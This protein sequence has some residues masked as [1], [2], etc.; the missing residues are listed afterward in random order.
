MKYI[1]LFICGIT[2]SS[3][4]L[5]SQN[6]QW[7]VYNTSNSGLPIN[8][9]QVIEQD[10]SGNIWIGTR[11][12]LTKFDG[13]T[14]VSW[15]P[16]NSNIKDDMVTSIVFDGTT[17][18]IGYAFLGMA[19][20]DGITFTH[21]NL[22]AIL[23]IPSY[24]GLGQVRGMDFDNNHNL[25]I[26]TYNGLL[27][28]D[29]IN[30]TRY[31][32]GNGLIGPNNRVWSVKCDRSTSNIVWVGTFDAGL[33]KFDGTNFTQYFF[34]DPSFPFLGG[35]QQVNRIIF[36]QEGDI[37]VTGYG[38][39]EFDRT[40]MQQKTVYT[41][42]NGLGDPLVWGIAFDHTGK[43]WIG[44]D[45]LDGVF[46]LDNGTWITYNETNSGFPDDICY[47]VMNIHVDA[48]NNVW[49]AHSSKGIVVYNEAGNVGIDEGTRP[50]LELNMFPNP[51]ND[52]I[53]FHKKTSEITKLEVFDYTGKL[54]K[55]AFNYKNENEVEMDISALSSGIYI[56]KLISGS[57][58]QSGKFVKK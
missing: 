53:A 35:L 57:S 54:V 33:L 37:W 8:N 17:I 55:A 48:F 47:T 26:A 13:T 41:S 36:D 49:M 46:C 45:C 23:N 50:K 38:V 43:L 2:F 5:L 15:T 19:K 22:S 56:C 52:K 16:L 29:G 7:K 25:W 14:W 10:L 30:F 9:A 11:G 42:N 39:I 51:A 3:T 21:Y 44:S 27:K 18:W 1:L 6:N 28:F 40:T 32:T 4:T 31:H 20:F 12:G 58:V 34:Y 24:Q